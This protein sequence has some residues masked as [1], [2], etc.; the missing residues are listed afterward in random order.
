MIRVC[1]HALN[2]LYKLLPITRGAL[3]YVKRMIV[4][5]KKS[6]NT[7]TYYRSQINAFGIWKY[8]VVNERLNEPR[9]ERA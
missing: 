1:E 3:K 7:H 4:S 2:A 5:E 6:Y 8:P 9:V